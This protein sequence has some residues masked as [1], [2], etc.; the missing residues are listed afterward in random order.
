MPNCSQVKTLVRINFP[1]RV[2]DS[3]LGEPIVLSAVRV[4]GLR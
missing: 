2:S 3:L 4:A 1:E